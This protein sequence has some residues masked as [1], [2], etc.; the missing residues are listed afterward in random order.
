VKEDVSPRL[1]E[2]AID[3]ISDFFSLAGSEYAANG[4]ILGH[5]RHEFFRATR[6]QESECYGRPC[7]LP[8]GPAASPLT[9]DINGIVS[10]YLAGARSFELPVQAAIARSIARAGR[11]KRAESRTGPEEPRP[12]MKVLRDFSIARLAALAL[13]RM[14]SL[15]LDSGPL[16]PCV[17]SANL[18][19]D[20]DSEAGDFLRALSDDRGIALRARLLDDFALLAAGPDPFAGTDLAGRLA[21]VNDLDKRTQKGFIAALTVAI[22]DGLPLKDAEPKLLSLISDSNMPVELKIGPWILGSERL[23]DILRRIGVERD[24]RLFGRNAATRYSNAVMTI[25]RLFTLARER[26]AFFGLRIDGSLPAAIGRSLAGPEAPGSDT[27]L[28]GNQSFAA[29]LNLAAK[30][31]EDL[32]GTLPLS[33]SGGLDAQRAAVLFKAGL[34]PLNLATALYSPEGF[35]ALRPIAK[36]INEIGTR[37]P[38]L[39]DHALIDVRALRDYSTSFLG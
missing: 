2:K 28:S 11:Q 23:S 10:A 37:G 1:A 38:G 26:N 4:T 7:A 3:S 33:F 5:G 14:L 22:P 27:F 25:R 20:G 9:I 12:A 13:G 35:G 8:V 16:E 36:A 6:E 21:K 34:R 19:A 39:R 29:G 17:Y 18:S 15:D 31:S 30:L 32:S 24:P